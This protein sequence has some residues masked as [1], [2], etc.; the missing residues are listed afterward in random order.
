LKS[1]IGVSVERNK[2]ITRQSERKHNG[3]G[4]MNNKPV[5]KT[6]FK[7]QINRNKIKEAFVLFK[8]SNDRNETK[9]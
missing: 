6:Q 5:K 3:V 2:Q 1:L 8:K 9:R 7:I 4:R